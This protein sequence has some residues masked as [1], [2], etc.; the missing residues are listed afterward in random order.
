MARTKLNRQKQTIETSA[1]AEQDT[2]KVWVDGRP[3]YRKVIRGTFNVTASASIPVAHGISGL[4]T[5]LEIIS[6][7]GGL[8]IGA[9]AV[10]GG[11]MQ[12]FNQ[13][14]EIAGNW[15]GFTSFD[16]TNI[17]FTSSFAWGTSW[18]TAIIEYV[19]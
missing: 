1:A 18:V 8:K 12:V 17:V 3:I 4:T 6:L 2:G 13:Y 19:K 11:Q 14:R 10:S 16:Q 5:S 7:S 15:L 9:G